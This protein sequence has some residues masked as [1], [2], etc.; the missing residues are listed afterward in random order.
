MV[1][2]ENIRQLNGD[3][4]MEKLQ[5]RRS[6]LKEYA[7]FHYAYINK[8]LTV[9][10]TEDEDI[11]DV[12]LL[13]DNHLK[14][15][16]YHKEHEEDRIIY[17]KIIDGKITKELRLF[18]L[19]KKDEF[20]ISGDNKSTVLIRIIGGSGADKLNSLSEQAHVEAYDKAD[21]MKLEGHKVKAHIKDQKGI[22]KYDRKDWGQDRFIQFPMLSF[23]TDE[24]IGLSYNVLWKNFGFRKHPFQ[25]NHNLQLAF[26]AGNNAIV[27]SYKAYFPEA[28]GPL[29]FSLDIDSKGPTFTQFYYGLG[30]RDQ[31]FEA[32][33]PGIQEA[34]DPSFHIVR[35]IHF[36]INP[37]FVKS[38][39]GV[40]QLRFNPS[41]EYINL[42]ESSDDERFYLLDNAGITDYE[43]QGKMYM[44]LGMS[45]SIARIDNP[46]IPSRGFEFNLAVDAKQNLDDS[47]YRN[48]NF[49]SN[50]ETYFPFTQ[51]HTVVLAMNMGGAITFGEY[52]FFHAN[53][54]ANPSRLR[55]YKTNRFAG[56]KMLYHASD[57]R[58]L[59]ARGKGDFPVSFGIFGSFDIGRVWYEGDQNV[60][61]ADLWH[62]NFGGGLF[63]TPLDQIGFKIGYYKSMRD[64]QLSIGGA[65]TF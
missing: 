64:S 6:K 1:W 32:L 20:N 21:G 7:A 52:E 42:N 2:P 61:D 45:Y 35:G 33:Y 46:A 23:Y 24:G 36:D 3:E 15:T 40:A 44:G 51:S 4:I 26:Y 28:F 41:L 31:D 30:N 57:L 62:H 59:I 27:A 12:E 54:L 9:S 53:Y 48:I 55:A 49:S 10:G 38:L 25:S 56:D 37:A 50:L 19:K 22:N 60:S 11:F 39:N 17:S 8:E 65:I 43:L 5:S 63:L 13:E 58:V 16:V 47:A 14:L 34:D 18:G 29:D